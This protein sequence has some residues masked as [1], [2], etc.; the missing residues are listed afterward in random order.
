MKLTV[1]ADTHY[2]A[3]SLGVTGEAYELRSGS[4]Q[5][6]LGES[7]EI[8][9]EAFGRIAR[10]GAEAVL[11]AGDLSNN[12]E[13]A[14][15]EGMRALLYDLQ[16]S[17][18]VYVVTA[19][20]DWCSN[21][22]A[23][24]YVGGEVI[25]GVPVLGHEELRDF[26]FG[27]GPKQAI[28]EFFTHLGTSS[29]VV[30][31]KEK[32]WLLALND[33]QN[34]KGRA[35][36]TP[37][38]AAWIVEQLRAAKERGITV[39][40]M[41]HHLVLP[42]ISPLI[43]GGSC[44]GDREEVAEMLADAGLRYLFVGHTHMQSILRYESPAGN[45][46]YEINVG[47]LCGYPAPIVQVTVEDGGLAVKT[48][49]LETRQDFLKDK[50]T[51]LVTR[52]LDSAAAGDKLEF[53]RRVTAM[54]MKGDKIAKY[55]F[56]I[57]PAARWLNKLTVR[58]AGKLIRVLSLGKAVKRGE[59]EDYPDGLAIDLAMEIFLNVFDGG[60][61]RHK[62]GSGTYKAAMALARLTKKQSLMDAMDTI[63]TGGVIDINDAFL[64]CCYQR[65]CAAPTRFA[66]KRRL[67]SRS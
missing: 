25:Q 62:R 58:R 53:A 48:E 61:H 20:H 50:A 45:T 14:S 42:H 13:R 30:E 67:S 23:S 46:L 56:M 57:K 41:Q 7:H 35:G 32:I 39:I 19:T 3:K 65:E 51:G 43:T 54:Q 11:I 6:C 66:P 37:E 10:S 47:A 63:L 17:K 2:Y 12:G 1:I 64:P 34:G 28:S 4:D 21:K 24:R 26:Y 29:Y 5:K 15:H 59:I 49:Y 52:M 31:L 38:H 27:F 55:F 44:V 18:P 36:Y 9:E 16:K 22:K 8:I 60:L 40:G 33:D